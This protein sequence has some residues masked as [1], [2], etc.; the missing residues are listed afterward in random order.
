[1][2]C[3]I[4][5]RL[6]AHALRQAPVIRATAT[7]YAAGGLY[8]NMHAL[9]AIEERAAAEPRDA[10]GNGPTIVFNGDFNFFNTAVEWW[11]ELNGRVREH[12]FATAGNVEVESAAVEDSGGC[13]C[14]YPVHVSPGVVERS[15]RIVSALRATA[16]AADTPSLV[17]W[18]R[19]LPR[20]A[21]AEVGVDR[22]RVGIVHGDVDSLAGWQL[23]VEA[24]EPADIS[25]RTSLGCD[26]Q[27]GAAHLPTTPH[28][29]I[30]GWCNDADVAGLLCTHTCLPFGQLLAT[31]GRERLAVFNNGSAGMPNFAGTRFGLLT[32]VSSNPS[33]P[34]DS[35]YG[36][37]AGG[38]RWDALP[39]RYNHDAWLRQFES[40]WPSGSDAHTSYYA[41]LTDGPCGFATSQ[42]ARD[43][44]ALRT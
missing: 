32:R 9:Q 42:A 43:G 7:V 24:M 28:S 20:A 39:V 29:T 33:P 6:G 22:R 25:L 44:V 21:I 35:L 40:E 5:Y 3:P 27:H 18:L 8:G 36:G 37:Y 15:D 16:T 41:R 1:M 17:D 13:G 12:H 34:A 38:L 4:G 11:K 26:L 14:G 2:S 23:G 30:A 19:D 31:G 10:N